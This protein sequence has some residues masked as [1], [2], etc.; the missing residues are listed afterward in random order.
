MPVWIGLVTLCPVATGSSDRSCAI[1]VC[2]GASESVTTNGGPP[3]RRFCTELSVV[4]FAFGMPTC[5]Y[6]LVSPVDSVV[7]VALRLAIST[8]MGTT[9]TVYE[10][11]VKPGAETVTVPV[12]A[13]SPDACT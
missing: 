4:L 12:V 3:A 9:L 13:C 7:V 10:S 2:A 5:T 1:G 11:L 8:P 6:H